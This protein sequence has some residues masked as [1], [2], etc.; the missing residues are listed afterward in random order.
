[1]PAVDTEIA[2]VEKMFG[3][4]VF[5]AMRMVRHFHRQL[6]AARGLIV[7]IGSIAGI[8][9]FVYGASYN[10]SKAALVHYGNTLR[11]E[12]LP[13]G[14]VKHPFQFRSAAASTEQERVA[15]ET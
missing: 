5:G 8:C 6:I 12:M 1:M 9:P 15:A 4:N 7:N 10:A 13:F 14:S 3:V 2:Q 11:V